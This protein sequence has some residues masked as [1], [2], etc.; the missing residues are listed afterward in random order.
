MT[1]LIDKEEKKEEKEPQNMAI[2]EQQKQQP[3]PAS[4]P[5]SIGGTAADNHAARKKPLR[6]PL[7]IM[8]AV[9]GDCLCQ[10]GFPFADKNGGGQAAQFINIHG[11]EFIGLGA[12]VDE[13]TPK[14]RVYDTLEQLTT[15]TERLISIG[16]LSFGDPESST[17]LNPSAEKQTDDNGVMIEC[18]PLDVWNKSYP[19]DQSMSRRVKRMITNIKVKLN[20]RCYCQVEASFVVGLTFF[21]VLIVPWSVQELRR[22]DL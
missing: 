13:L 5:P 18:V 1:V 8:K 6:E 4:P 21:S 2:Y 3:Q 22:S 12:V 7:T 10:G 14:E 16:Y 19:N 9:F 20:A 17:V 15:R 11:I